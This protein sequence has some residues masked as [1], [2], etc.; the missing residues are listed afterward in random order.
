[1]AVAGFN[2]TVKLT[3]TSTSMTTEACTSISSTVFQVTNTAKRILDPDTALTVYDNG[4]PV[5][6]GDVTIDYLFGKI[7]FGSPPTAPVTI[8]A[9]YL[10][11]HAVAEGRSFSIQQTRDELESTAFNTTG[12]KSFILGLKQASGSIEGLD[13]LDTDIDAGAGSVVPATLHSAGTVKVLE[14]YLG[15]G[16]LGTW[17]GF[18]L[19]SGLQNDSSVGELAK[20]TI[21]WKTVSKVGTDQTEGSSFG[22]G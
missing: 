20:G 21:T 15:G 4:S 6:D 16:T 10:P 22:L 14:V 2:C 1:M 19:L 18:V 3:G 11:T 12:V 5:A 7:T 9:N 17:R 8:T 13:M